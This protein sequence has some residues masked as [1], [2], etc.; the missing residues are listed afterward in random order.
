M[1]ITCRETE[2]ISQAITKII[3]CF[4]F[5]LNRRNHSDERKVFPYSNNVKIE[6]FYS[7]GENDVSKT[8]NV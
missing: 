5:F 3:A 8:Q 7:M 2:N 6:C 1:D 4:I